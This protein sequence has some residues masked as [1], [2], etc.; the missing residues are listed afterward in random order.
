M[1]T[2]VHRNHRVQVV[3]VATWPPVGTVPGPGVLGIWWASSQLWFFSLLGLISNHSKYIWVGFFFSCIKTILRSVRCVLQHMT[4]R[5]FTSVLHFTSYLVSSIS[6]HVSWSSAVKQKG[7]ILW[8][9][10]SLSG[11]N[12]MSPL[13]N[14]WWGRH[15]RGSLWENWAAKQNWYCW[16]YSEGLQYSLLA[17][18]TINTDKQKIFFL[19]VCASK[20]YWFRHLVHPQNT[21]TGTFAAF[22]KFKNSMSRSTIQCNIDFRARQRGEGKVLLP[23]ASKGLRATGT[24]LRK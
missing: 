2:I 7:P 1:P 15:M 9:Q 22:L 21:G 19:S 5:C 11:S 24:R 12:L 17:F 13:K 23:G 10:R 16:Q 20:R 8:C 3:E 14:W 4:A 6:A 18:E